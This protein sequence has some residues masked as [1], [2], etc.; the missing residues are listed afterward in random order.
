MPKPTGPTNPL[1]KQLIES[2]RE[3][4]HKE[5]AG[6]LLELARLLERPERIRVEVDL[7]QIDRNAEKGQTIVVPGRVLAGGSMSKP[8]S[9]AAAFISGAA[10]EGIENAG[11][12][13]LSIPELVAKNPKGTGVRIMI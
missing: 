9:V 3:K 4:G 2:L 12:K 11:G 6:F 10:K 13:V 1:L 8:V 5:N 7:S